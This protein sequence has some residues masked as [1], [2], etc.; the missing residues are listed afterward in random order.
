MGDCYP[1]R[2]HLRAPV[3]DQRR[4]Y[5]VRRLVS[6]LLPVRR[7]SLSLR[8]QP[9]PAGPTLPPGLHKV[10]N[11]GALRGRHWFDFAPHLPVRRLGRSSS[12]FPLV[13]EPH[14]RGGIVHLVLH[15]HCV[16]PFSRRVAS[17]RHQPRHT[18]VHI[19]FA[20]LP[21]MDSI[22]VFCNRRRLSEISCLLGREV[23]HKTVSGGI[24][25]SPNFLGIVWRGE[26]LPAKSAGK[27]Q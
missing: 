19:A 22:D 4:Y 1:E 21:G 10:R 24:L 6:Q 13:P 17:T 5:R 7:V 12:G 2:R 25:G 15:L 27:A 26:A 20:T 3:R 8:P 11:T 14:H 23:E 16:H 18:P 9:N